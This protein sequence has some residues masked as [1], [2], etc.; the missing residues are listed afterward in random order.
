[1]YSFLD[2]LINI[3]ILLFKQKLAEIILPTVC[4]LLL[5]DRIPD[6]YLGIGYSKENYISQPS[7]QL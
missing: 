5:L 2:I 3:Y 1:M 7:L 6:S 4:S